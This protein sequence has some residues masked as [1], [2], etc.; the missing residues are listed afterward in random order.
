[1]KAAAETTELIRVT[2]RDDGQQAV[3]A[4]DLYEFL[5]VRRDFSTWCKQMFAYGFEEN[6][7]FFLLTKIGEQKSRGGHNAID[8]ALD[9]DCAKEIAMIQRSERGRQARRYFIEVEKRYRAIRGG[10]A[11]PAMPDFA[12]PAAAARA[13]AEQWEARLSAERQLARLSEKVTFY[14]SVSADSHPADLLDMN[15]AAKVLRFEGVGRTRLFEILREQKILRANNEP[16]QK[17]VDS[18]HFCQVQSHWHD[19]EGEGH[20]YLKT[21]VTQ[22]GLEA[23]HRLLTRLE[24]KPIE[25][26]AIPVGLQPGAMDPEPEH[27][28]PRIYLSGPRPAME[29]EPP[30]DL[31]LNVQPE[32]DTNNVRIACDLDALATSSLTFEWGKGKTEVLTPGLT[33]LRLKSRID[34]VAKLAR[35]KP[36]ESRCFYRAVGYYAA[37][38]GYYGQ[39]I[40]SADLKLRH[41]KATTLEEI[42]REYREQRRGVVG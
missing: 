41:R 35:K 3:S 39:E 40:T 34:D 21:V 30:V 16:Y 42:R 19:P 29:P 13:W 4:R 11:A 38:C 9:L 12:N 7:D 36:Q 2:E 32:D 1:M 37:L 33:L 14:E 22:R 24:Y 17:Y 10:S 18:G 23:L 26:R 8:Y 5:G 31:T 25:G 28:G 6:Q 20:V 27:A 15:Q